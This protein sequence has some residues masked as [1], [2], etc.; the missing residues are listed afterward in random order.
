V[1]PTAAMPS[2]VAVP[3]IV[4]VEAATTIESAAVVTAVEPGTRADEH[5]PCEVI[6]TVV[7][8]RRASIRWIPV[9][10]IGANRR[11]RNVSRPNSDPNS[12]PNLRMG[13]TPCT[14]NHYQKRE[15]NSVF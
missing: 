10:A 13:S 11:R 7:P 15:Q 3:S 2:A 5:A 12:K 8:V 9:I 6:R 4:A 1:K 14:C